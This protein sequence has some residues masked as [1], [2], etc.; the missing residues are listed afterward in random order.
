VL[1]ALPL[2]FAAITTRLHGH[3][4]RMA[5]L[6]LGYALFLGTAIWLATFPVSIEV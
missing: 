4:P 5:I 2:F 6:G 3:R 1:F